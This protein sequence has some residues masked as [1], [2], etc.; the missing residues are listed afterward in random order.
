MANEL[1]TIQHE[2]S[3]G[4]SACKAFNK[5]MFDP[6]DPLN[7]QVEQ[8]Y[9]LEIIRNSPKLQRCMPETIRRSM[10]ELASMGLSLSPAKKEAYLIP[11]KNVCTV[12]PSYMGFEQMLYRTGLIALIDADV[13]K[14]N[15]DWL[16]WADTTGK[17]FR[18]HKAEGERGPVIAAWCTVKLLTGETKV[19]TMDE[20]AL[21][22]CRDAAA[23]KNNDEIPFVWKG[24]FRDEMYKKCVIRRAFKHLPKTSNPNVVRALEALNNTD[25]MDFSANDATMVDISG[26]ISPEQI[27][28][29]I[30]IMRDAGYPEQGINN[31]LKALASV[32]GCKGKIRAVPM[33]RWEETV[34]T[35]KD[36]LKKWHEMKAQNSTS[37]QGESTARKE[38]I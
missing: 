33:S 34:A 14:K 20:E 25:P 32:M 24:P 10:V 27:N 30:R 18:H 29:L 19:E 38:A 21:R 35:C 11:Y 5:A 16:E 9:A 23:K 6:K 37:K 2:L 13:V 36:G 1:V 7:W 8:G 12:S 4:G 15:D 31:Q 22:G 3:R 26:T 28:E 17:K